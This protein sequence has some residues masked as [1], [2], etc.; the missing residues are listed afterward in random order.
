[1]EQIPDYSCKRI[2]SRD[3]HKEILSTP[4]QG[5][6]R[7]FVLAYFIASDDPNNEVGI[8]TIRD[9]FF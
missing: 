7:L 1:M 3:W 5:V 4:F 9:I 8:K 2:K 6:K